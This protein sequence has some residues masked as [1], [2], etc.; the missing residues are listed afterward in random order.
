M[1]LLLLWAAMFTIVWTV[2]AWD[3]KRDGLAIFWGL[4]TAVLFTAYC[5]NINS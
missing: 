3:N 1:S 2:G 4:V 5:M